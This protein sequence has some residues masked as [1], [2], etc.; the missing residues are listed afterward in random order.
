MP[1]LSPLPALCLWGFLLGPGVFLF[2]ICFAVLL[3]VAYH[4]PG[5]PR[6]EWDDPYVCQVSQF[7]SFLLPGRL[8]LLLLL[9]FPLSCVLFFRRLLW[10]SWLHPVLLV[11]SP[12]PC[13]SFLVAVP[14]AGVSLAHPFWVFPSLGLGGGGAAPAECAA[15]AVSTLFFLWLFRPRLPGQLAW[16]C[17]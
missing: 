12:F 1:S 15:S 2:S 9:A 16:E 4:H 5:L 10:L 7:S 3:R 14:F 11:L 17:S 6:R 8:F 13:S